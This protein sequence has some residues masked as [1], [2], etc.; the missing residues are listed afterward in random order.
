MA[1]PTAPPDMR[2]YDL[3]HSFGAEIYRLTG[4]LATVARFLGHAPGSTVTARYALGANAHVD[5][6]AV[7]AFNAARAADH[8]H[9][10]G[11][12]LPAKAARPDK[13]RRVKRFR[14]VS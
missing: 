7:D 8:V 1:V 9:A 5:R 2:L 4:D 11:D 6:A 3:R 13:A 10:T 14:K 12:K